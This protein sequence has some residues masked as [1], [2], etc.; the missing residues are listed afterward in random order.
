MKTL[1]EEDQAVVDRVKELLQA[2]FDELTLKAASADKTALKKLIDK[3]LQYVDNADKYT[4]EAIR[5]L[6][7]YMIWQFPYT[8]TQRRLRQR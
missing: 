4:E 5:S 3:S 7:R 2:A 1:T 8:R 6:R